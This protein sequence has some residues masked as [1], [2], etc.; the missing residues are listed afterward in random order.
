MVLKIS[1]WIKPI[2]NFIIFSCCTLFAFLRWVGYLTLGVEKLLQLEGIVY[3]LQECGLFFFVISF[4]LFL[5][6]IFISLK[7]KGI[8]KNLIS[9]QFLF[10][11]LRL[12]LVLGF[13]YSVLPAF[14]LYNALLIYGQ[15]VSAAL[16]QISATPGLEDPNWWMTSM[17]EGK[18]SGELSSS[19][20]E[21]GKKLVATVEQLNAD[22]GRACLALR[23]LVESVC[24]EKSFFDR[25][26]LLKGFNIAQSI[27]GFPDS[28]CLDFDWPKKK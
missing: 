18:G 9:R 1:V 11:F 16:L 4:L 27:T 26:M 15:L 7:Q 5:Y 6:E 14:L 20:E 13:A 22:K 23:Y 8:F 2:M 19:S 25:N 10:D 17:M 21:P 28:P 12:A 3:M 24:S